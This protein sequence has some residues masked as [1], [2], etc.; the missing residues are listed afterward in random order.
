MLV[1]Y[2]TATLLSRT[3]LGH[4][5]GVE[6]VVFQEPRDWLD[7]EYEMFVKIEQMS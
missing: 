1:T 6:Q 7:G 3:D 4:G 5:Q 2:E